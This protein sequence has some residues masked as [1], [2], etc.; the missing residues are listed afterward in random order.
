M[1]MYYLKAKEVH[2]EYF[3]ATSNCTQ[4][5]IFWSA[6]VFYSNFIWILAS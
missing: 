4:F 5:L 6:L 1:I 2:Y 3:G